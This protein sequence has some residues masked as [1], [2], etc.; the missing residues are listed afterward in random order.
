MKRAS[1]V[2]IRIK[3][4]QDLVI[5]P[6]SQQIYNH[7]LLLSKA[8]DSKDYQSALLATTYSLG[9]ST[10]EKCILTPL[11]A[12]VSSFFMPYLHSSQQS[13]PKLSLIG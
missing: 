2:L 7:R 10:H 13:E 1:S 11:L 8:L 4:I 5:G 3:S 12:R 9:M 6:S